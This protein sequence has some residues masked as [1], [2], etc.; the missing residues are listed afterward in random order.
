MRFGVLLGGLSQRPAGHDMRKALSEILTFVQLAEDLGFDYV[1]LG[2]HFLSAPYQMFQPIPLAARIAGATDRLAIVCSVLLPLHHPVSLVETLATLDVVTDGR[3]MLS[4]M[5][6]YRDEEYRAF[7]IDPASRVSRF[8]ECLDLVVRLLT[9]ETV[10]ASGRHYPLDR[11]S[12]AMRGLQRPHPEIWIAGNSDGAV[13]RAARRGLRWHVNPHATLGT[14]ARQGAL[15]RAT[16]DAAGKRTPPFALS[17]ELYCAESDRAAIAEVAPFMSSKYVAYADW[18]QDKV[19]PEVS[20][21]TDTFEQLAEDRFIIGSPESCARRLLPCLEL[22][23]DHLHFRLVW[24]G[25]TLA[26]AERALRIT[27]R[28]VLPMVRERAS[29]IP[30]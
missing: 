1:V 18:G 9:E 25:M 15:Y 10:T 21:F 16:A 24:P 29:D 20:R 11:A 7:Q 4:F 14:I 12:I 30:H 23:V 8:N 17:R 22:G 13:K 27:A 2:Q 5:L 26:S 6:G 3:L 19:L 28:E